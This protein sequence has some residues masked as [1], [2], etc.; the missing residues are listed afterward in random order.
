MLR[1]WSATEGQEL[2][3]R[4]ALRSGSWLVMIKQ[5]FFDQQG[6]GEIPLH[7]VR[8][9]GVTLMAQVHQSL[10]NPDLVREALAG[11]PNGE[12]EQAEKGSSI[13]KRFSTAV[14]RQRSQ[15]PRIQPAG[16]PQPTSSP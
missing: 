12:V 10:Y 2:A 6:E 14:L 1:V 15:S 4:V 9:L 3:M 13:S 16:N 5:G 11:D 8:G 7:V